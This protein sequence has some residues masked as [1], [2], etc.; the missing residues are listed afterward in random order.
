M[1]I[2]PK[3]RFLANDHVSPGYTLV[4]NGFG[5]DTFQERI[6]YLSVL[7]KAGVCYLPLSHFL[8]SSFL[9]THSVKE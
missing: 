5:N 6:I 7:I 2:I 3:H 8:A 4:I 9:V 1:H